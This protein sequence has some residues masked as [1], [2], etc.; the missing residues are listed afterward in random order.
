MKY[1]V[2]AYFA[3]KGKPTVVKQGKKLLTDL[4]EAIE[5]AYKVADHYH[6]YTRIARIAQ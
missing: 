1:R 4:K 2:D 3:S 5:L 6:C